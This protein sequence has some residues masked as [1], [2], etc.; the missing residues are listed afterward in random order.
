MF[1]ADDEY[2]DISDEY[3]DE[4]EQD[5]ETKLRTSVE[6]LLGK[7]KPSELYFLGHFM[8]DLISSCSWKGVDCKKG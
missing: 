6:L 2:A 5:D 8:E 4:D 3:P 1:E 7:L